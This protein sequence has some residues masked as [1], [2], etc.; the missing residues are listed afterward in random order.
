MLTYFRKK[1]KLSYRCLSRLSHPVPLEFN[2]C[3]QREICWIKKCIRRAC[4]RARELSDRTLVGAGHEPNVY[5]IMHMIIKF[6][7]HYRLTFTRKRALTWNQLKT[8]FGSARAY[9]FW[10]QRIRRCCAVISRSEVENWGRDELSSSRWDKAGK[11]DIHNVV[12][13]ERVLNIWESSRSQHVMTAQKS[14]ELT[15][16][17]NMLGWRAGIII[18]VGNVNRK[19]LNFGIFLCCSM[20]IFSSLTNSRFAGWISF[21]R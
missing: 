2:E 4:V 18:T 13:S 8:S 20:V 6:K 21:A 10:C 1:C 19:M 11:C 14:I 3:V 16:I 15:I 17:F 5:A 12:V 9:H 7:F